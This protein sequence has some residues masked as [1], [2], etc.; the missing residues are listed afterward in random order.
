MEWLEIGVGRVIYRHLGCFLNSAHAT[1]LIQVHVQGGSFCHRLVVG[2]ELNLMVV[3][4]PI[5]VGMCG[6]SGPAAI[7][8]TC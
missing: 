6:G 3:V 5:A 1:V 8:T 7:A 4:V 2:H